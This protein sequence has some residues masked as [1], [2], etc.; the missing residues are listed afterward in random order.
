M[1]GACGKYGGDKKYVRGNVREKPERP[2]SRWEHITLDLKGTG[3]E[4]RGW[5]DLT[6]NRQVDDCC[7]YGNKS[8]GFTKC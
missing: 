6:Q 3:W 4:V 5:T 2:R 1:D 8:L 7:K